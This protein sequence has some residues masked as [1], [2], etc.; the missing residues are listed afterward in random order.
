MSVSMQTKLKFPLRNVHRERKSDMPTNDTK[1]ERI[2]QM[3][4]EQKWCENETIFRWNMYTERA[5]E[6][7]SWKEINEIVRHTQKWWQNLSKV[8]ANEKKTQHKIALSE[9]Q[10]LQ[11][12]LLKRRILAT[13]YQRLH[14]CVWQD[15]FRRCYHFG[16][17]HES[18]FYY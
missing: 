5:E 7:F 9:L 6:K 3:Q 12:L 16:S 8:V 13:L 15:N 17:A 10:L 14:V 11:W 4:V 18:D 1:N 2:I